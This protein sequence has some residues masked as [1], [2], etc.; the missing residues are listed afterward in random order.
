MKSKVTVITLVCLLGLALAG[1]WATTSDLSQGE[2]QK[3]KLYYGTYGSNDY[4]WGTVNSSLPT[5][6]WLY[7]SEM[8]GRMMDNACAT[9]G[10]YVY[11]LAGYGTS[12]ALYRHAIGSTTWETRASCPLDISNGGAGIIGDTLYYCSGYSYGMGGTVDTLFKYCISTNTWT[13]G[14]GPFTGTTYNWQPLVLVCGGKLYYI[15]GCNQPGATNPTRNVWCYTP[16][17][18]WSQVADMNKGR[19]FA[20]GCVYHDT[21]WVTGGVRNDTVINHS[22]F[23]DPASNTWTV[24]TTIFPHMPI[25]TWGAASGVVGQTMFV[26]SGVSAAMQLMDTT[27]YFDFGTR[28]WTVTP[29]VLLKVYRS[30][31]VGNADG[32]AVVYGGSTGGFNPT[33]TCQYEQITTGYADDVGVIQI[34]APGS[35]IQPGSIT[36]KAR[37]KNFGTNPQSDIPVYCWI[38]SAGTRVYQ[39]S[40]TYA[41]PLEP[42]ATADVEFSPQWT[43]VGGTYNVTMFTDL[44]GDEN[45]AN[46]TLRGTTEVRSANLVWYNRTSAPSPGRYWCPGTGAVRDTIYFCGGRQQNATSVRTIT[47]YD[48]QNDTW[49][50]SGLPTLLTPRR[51]GA[52]GRIGNKIYVAGGRDSLSTTLNTCEEFDVDTK[53]VTA[54]A[55]MPAGAWA[56][57]GAVANNKLY[58]IG[59]ENRTGTTYEYDPATNTWSTKASCPVGRGWAAAVGAG[60]KVYVCGGAD[61]SN[62]ELRD[63]WE[64]NPATNT[65][66]Q[67]ANMPGTRIYHR[68]VAY[69]DTIIYVL[70]GSVTGTTPADNLVYR[71]HIPSNTWRTETPMNT[72]RGWEMAN[73]VGGSIW[74]AYGSDCTTPT[75]LTNL[76]EGIIPMSGIEEYRLD[77]GEGYAI[78]AVTPAKGRALLRFTVPKTGRVALGVYNATGS[79]VKMLVN[80]D[81]QPGSYSV[82][83]DRKDA[84]GRPVAA[85][86]YFYRLTIDGRSVSAKAILLQ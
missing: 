28:T 1:P 22:E 71:Y 10:N 32:K 86:T 46:D 82:T 40:A 54:K 68:A 70:G 74:V 9:D 20:M 72:R 3:V 8:P 73:V 81:F 65:W 34:V 4:F 48:I 64:Y 59:N 61:P 19:V 47:A 14:P 36:P 76:E 27:Q 50:T 60:G 37:I 57:C 51:A 25:A 33:D 23:Y 83:W 63:C 52:G 38:D 17:A 41:G 67:K 56:C 66:S 26:H 45:R 21:I 7:H 2:P 6:A 69:Q 77:L 24:D 55:N 12:N 11:V 49:I 31:G 16:G 30:T 42:G 79:L 5:D 35:I 29:S 80:S 58:V 62:A 44:S 13:S 43:A 75:Y 18:G 15:S 85:G 78:D 84:Q 39:R 53:T